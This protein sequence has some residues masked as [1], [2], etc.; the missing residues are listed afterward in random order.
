MTQVWK[1]FQF[2]FYKFWQEKIVSIAG[3]VL[4][5]KTSGPTAQAQDC[6]IFYHLFK[7]N[8]FNVQKYSIYFLKNLDLRYYSVKL[9]LVQGCRY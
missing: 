8:L 6:K 1:S 4:K 5:P 7:I 9:R 2:L 3:D